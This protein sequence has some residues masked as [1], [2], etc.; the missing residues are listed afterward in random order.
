M[1]KLFLLFLATAAMTLVSCGGSRSESSSDTEK[2]RQEKM[3]AEMAAE[4]GEMEDTDGNELEIEEGIGDWGDDVYKSAPIMPSFP[5]GN[6]AL[7]KFL[8]DNVRYPQSVVDTNIQGKVVVQFVVEKDGKVGEVKVVRSVHPDLDKEAIRVCKTLPKFNP[9]KD[10]NGEPVRVV[11]T[12]PVTFKPQTGDM[13]EAPIADAT[14]NEVA[15]EPTTCSKCGGSGEVRCS[16]C[17]GKG[18]TV[19]RQSGDSGWYDEVYYFK[20]YYGCKKCGGRGYKTDNGYA[21]EHMRKGSGKMK[22][23]KCHGTGHE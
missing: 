1:K 10:D 16:K 18:Y 22:C 11:Y 23:P 15:S 21:N 17:G 14:Q 19:K 9:G 7:M 13:S 8:S 6:G 20:S 4:L 3:A 5:G 12:L 2:Q